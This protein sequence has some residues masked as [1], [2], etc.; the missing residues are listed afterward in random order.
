MVGESPPQGTGGAAVEVAITVALVVPGVPQVPL[1]VFIR[2]NDG[3][4]L[5]ALGK[6]LENHFVRT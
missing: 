2:T 3:I 6:P 5:R 4:S 1:K